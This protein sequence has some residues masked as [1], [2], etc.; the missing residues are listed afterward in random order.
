MDAVASVL[1]GATAEVLDAWLAR[2][3]TP[4]QLASSVLILRNTPA[5]RRIMGE[6]LRLAQIYPLID[7]SP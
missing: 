6:W 1:P 2:S 7:D 3:V 5:T 4:G